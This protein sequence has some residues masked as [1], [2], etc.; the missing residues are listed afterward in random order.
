[1]PENIEVGQ[2]VLTQ[3]DCLW[4]GQQFTALGY[5]AA[6]VQSGQKPVSLYPDCNVASFP[7]Q[8]EAVA[9]DCWLIEYRWASETKY[10]LRSSAELSQPSPEQLEKANGMSLWKSRKAK[11]TEAELEEIRQLA[12]ALRT[13]PE[14][15]AEGR[16]IMD[17]VGT[18]DRLS[19]FLDALY[20]VRADG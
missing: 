7:A 13:A 15:S 20:E 10:G 3:H 14:G 4:T 11:A 2:P 12:Q 9:S 6:L 16:G 18:M 1:M 19:E 5:V 8:R 17:R